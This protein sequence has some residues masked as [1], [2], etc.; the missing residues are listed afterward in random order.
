M[1]F[2]QGYRLLAEPEPFF[3]PAPGA[4]P[5]PRDY[6]VM[7]FERTAPRTRSRWSL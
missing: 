2:Y 6:K 1:L 7:W 3:D 4:G 5:R